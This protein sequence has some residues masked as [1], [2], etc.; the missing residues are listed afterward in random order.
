[1]FN[2]HPNPTRDIFYIEFSSLLIQDIDIRVFNSVGE[3]IFNK[4]LYGFNSKY[5]KKIS[6]KEKAKGIYFIEIHTRNG[7][8]YEKIILH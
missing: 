7:I 6:L 2:I 1:M 8:I 5:K 4:N 3:T